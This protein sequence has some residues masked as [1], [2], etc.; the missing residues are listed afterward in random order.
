[1]RNRAD[2]TDRD[3]LRQQY[4]DPS[5]LRTR[6]RAHELYGERKESFRSWVIDQLDLMPGELIADVGCGPGTYFELLRERGARVVGCDL[7]PGM[8]TEALTKGFPAL[9]ADA[10]H[11]P[12]E[13]ASFDRVMCNHVLYHV[14]DQKQA[15]LELRRIA[16]PGATVL[17]TTNGADTLR[18]FADV[19]RRAARDV[20]FEIPA[21]RRSPFTLE[22]R[23]VVREVFPSADV[24]RFDNALVFPVPEPALD[25][26][27]SWIGGTGPL[28]E[29]MRRRISETIRAEG[30]FRVETIAGCFVARA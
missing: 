14:P 22:D 19:A 11:L 24:R 27:R 30:A 25:Y 3:S 12:F 6:V 28:E 2:F 13:R 4:G 26:V 10:Q 21:V 5:R 20:G 8:V 9:V 29:A 1:M 16:R 18:A 15:I 17:I 7:S 23:G